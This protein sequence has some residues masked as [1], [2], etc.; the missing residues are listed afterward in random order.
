MQISSSHPPP[1]LLASFTHATGSCD[2][3]DGGSMSSRPLEARSH[4]GQSCGQDTVQQQRP[5]PCPKPL[6]MATGPLRTLAS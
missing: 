4:R 6:G 3:Y 2:N 1:S 5:A